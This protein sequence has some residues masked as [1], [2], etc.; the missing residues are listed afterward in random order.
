M[1]NSHDDE[2]LRIRAVRHRLRVQPTGPGVH[3]DSNSS[4]RWLFQCP[5][6]SCHV[7]RS[8]SIDEVESAG[9]FP[10]GRTTCQLEVPLGRPVRGKPWQRLGD[11]LRP[12]PDWYKIQLSDLCSNP[13]TGGRPTSSVPNIFATL[14]TSRCPS[15]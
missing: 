14:R 12:A 3:T 9:L 7:P 8:R 6:S 13:H 10:K 11:L 1:R 4:S 2:Q 5:S 15:Q